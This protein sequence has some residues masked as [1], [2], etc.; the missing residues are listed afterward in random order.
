MSDEQAQAAPEG[1]QAAG[2]WRESLPQQ[3]RDAPY[4]REAKTADEAFAG[5]KGAAEYMGNSLRIPGPDAGAEAMQ[6]FYERVMEK[7]P[8][9]MRKPDTS[10]P[11]SFDAILKALGKPDSADKYQLPEID[12]Y[13]IP[14]ERIGRLKAIAHEAGLTA[15]QAAKLYQT[16]LSDEANSQANQLG[17]HQAQMQQLRGEWGLAYESRMAAARKALEA[18][19]APADVMAAFDNG[20]LAAEGIRWM[21]GLS[22]SLGAGEG[23]QVASQG[24]QSAPVM[25]PGEAA[26]QLEEIGRRIIGKRPADLAPGEYERLAKKRIDLMRLATAGG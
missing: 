14:D 26:A 6:K 19:K 3:L 24:S 2:D 8:G 21:Y 20:S 13:Q 17:E 11:E 1:A 5:I 9:L 23:G 7:A 10:D 12:G 15:D 22:Q 4:I 16:M 25:T 18:T